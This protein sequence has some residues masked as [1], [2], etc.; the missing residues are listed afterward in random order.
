MCYGN[1]MMC[2]IC[3][4]G[5]LRIGT[6]AEI[7]PKNNVV[8]QKKEGIGIVYIHESDLRGH[9]KMSKFS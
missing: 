2:L 4:Q 1:A 7:F 8:F 6:S 3:S 5:A 9:P